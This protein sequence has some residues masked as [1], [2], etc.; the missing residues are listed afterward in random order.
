MKKGIKLNDQNDKIDKEQWQLVI[1]RGFDSE[2][3]H[4][5]H[6]VTQYDEN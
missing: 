5:L 4:Q 1:H 2:G 6:M 3:I